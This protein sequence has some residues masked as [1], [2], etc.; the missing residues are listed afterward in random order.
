MYVEGVGS[1]KAWYQ[2]KPFQVPSVDQPHQ[3]QDCPASPL[4]SHAML[5]CTHELQ[6]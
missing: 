5:S 4:C 1:E 6:G 3:E 2:E